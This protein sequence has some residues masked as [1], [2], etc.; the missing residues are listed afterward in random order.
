VIRTN[1]ATRPFY[2]EQAVRL[3][4]IVIAV[5]AFSATMFNVVQMIQLSRRDTRLATQAS[6]DDARAAALRSQAT[7]LRG[8]VDQRLLESASADARQ[9]NDLIDRRTFSWT[10]L[11]NRFEKTLP[12]D[13]HFTAVRPKIDPK[14]GF[15]LTINLTAKRVED[16]NQFIEQLEATGAFAQI[17]KLGETVDE[18][19]QLQATLE[20]LYIP[21]AAHP[22]GG[23]E[24]GGATGAER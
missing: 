4:L 19:N 20:S 3:V 17:Q 23:T 12:D 14:R 6:R 2:N 11:F 15:V 13:V 22:E 9:A 5:L 16:V 1:L 18:Q 10:E 8:S 21:S 7:Q 24:N